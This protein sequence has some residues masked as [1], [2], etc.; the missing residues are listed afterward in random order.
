[1]GAFARGSGPTRSLRSP[2]SPA[3][4]EEGQEGQRT[5]HPR[6]RVTLEP[7]AE[8]EFGN[9]P[10]CCSSLGKT[11]LCITAIAPGW[12]MNAA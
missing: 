10:G 7:L 8:R 2:S 11:V 5:S 12:T 4:R 1:M 9:L 6:Q 3:F